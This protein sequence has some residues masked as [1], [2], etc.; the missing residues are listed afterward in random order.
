MCRWLDHCWKLG[1]LVGCTSK[2]AFAIGINVTV[3][4]LADPRIG[5]MYHW[6]YF[7]VAGFKALELTKTLVQTHEPTLLNVAVSSVYM[8]KCRHAHRHWSG[9]FRAS[10][11]RRGVICRQKPW[12]V[13]AQGWRGTGCWAH[14]TGNNDSSRNNVTNHPIAS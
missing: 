6:D 5:G 9:S 4:M 3:V 13:H 10:V 1:V 12:K 11:R 8:K 7:D 14:Y 2:P